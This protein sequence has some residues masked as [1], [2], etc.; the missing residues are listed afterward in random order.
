MIA[1]VTDNDPAATILDIFQMQVEELAHANATLQQEQKH[2]PIPRSRWYGEQSRDLV[3]GQ[4]TR[5]AL[6]STHAHRPSASSTPRLLLFSVSFERIT[7]DR[8]RA[9][10][11]QVLVERRHPSQNAVDSR[12]REAV[13]DNGGCRG[14]STSRA[15]PPVG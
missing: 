6:D 11:H 10:Q 8:E 7:R 13:G 9:C 3:I 4:G 15:A 12:R 5:N 14:L 1:P 2:G